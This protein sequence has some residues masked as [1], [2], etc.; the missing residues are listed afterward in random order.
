MERR[1]ELIEKIKTSSN[2]QKN[3]TR[4]FWKKCLKKTLIG[5]IISLLFTVA[6]VIWYIIMPSV[7]LL[8]Y[9]IACPLILFFIILM[10]GI[11]HYKRCFDKYKSITA[12]HIYITHISLTYTLK[13]IIYTEHYPYKNLKKIYFKEKTHEIIFEKN[14]DIIIVNQDD[15]SPETFSF[16]QTLFE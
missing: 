1:T 5:T 15:I 13:G 7:M 10:D 6:F 4:E 11:Y 2:H 12:I 9:C 3:H 14:N 8:Y 16:L